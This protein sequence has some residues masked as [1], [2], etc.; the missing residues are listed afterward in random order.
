[1]LNVCSFARA[2][3]I[4]DGYSEVAEATLPKTKRKPATKRKV[5]SATRK[6]YDE[7]ETAQA[8]TPQ[9]RKELAE[10]R[11]KAGLNDFLDWVQDCA[12]ELNTANGH[13][14]AYVQNPTSCLSS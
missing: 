1:M 8:R 14:V 9:Q 13:Q 7:K 3:S 12:K 10:K 2:S 4:A 6:L 11:K 5:S